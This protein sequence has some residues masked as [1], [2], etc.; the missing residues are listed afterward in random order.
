[1]QNKALFYSDLRK[2]IKVLFLFFSNVGFFMNQ[3]VTVFYKCIP[4]TAKFSRYVRLDVEKLYFLS[5]ITLIIENNTTF[6]VS[7]P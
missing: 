5:F 7:F 2:N 3:K 6:I 1:M 4:I